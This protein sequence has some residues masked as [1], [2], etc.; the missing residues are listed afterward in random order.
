[1]KSFC[2]IGGAVRAG[3][4]C[5]IELSMKVPFIFFYLKQGL[6]LICLEVT[7]IRTQ[8]LLLTVGKKKK[9]QNVCKHI[10]SKRIKLESP[11]WSGL[12]RF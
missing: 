1:M 10:T 9:I 5:T 3:L 12:V 11:G 6:S 7:Y 2:S 4:D 8:L